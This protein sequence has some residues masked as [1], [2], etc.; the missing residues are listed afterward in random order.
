[1]QID[2]YESAAAGHMR[3][4]FSRRACMRFIM[5]LREKSESDTESYAK[6]IVCCECAFRVR[7]CSESLRGLVRTRNDVG[8]LLLVPIVVKDRARAQD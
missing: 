1:M 2:E 7:L 8:K 6:Q 3:Q 4:S 5:M